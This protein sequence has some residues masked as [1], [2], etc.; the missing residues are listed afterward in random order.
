MPNILLSKLV[1]LASLAEKVA[2]FGATRNK[3]K[4]LRLQNWPQLAIDLPLLP[5]VNPQ[6]FGS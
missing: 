1:V 2:A 3:L 4:T 5:L 6:S